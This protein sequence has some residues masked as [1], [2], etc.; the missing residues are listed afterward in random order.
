MISGFWTLTQRQEQDDDVR[1]I[2]HHAK[3]SETGVV[4][5]IDHNPYQWMSQEAFE[6]HVWLEFPESPTIGPWSNSEIIEA[7][8]QAA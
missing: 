4:K 7:R 2:W 5:F 3:H 6:A 1:K 8:R